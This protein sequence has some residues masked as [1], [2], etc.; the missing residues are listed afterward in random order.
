VRQTGSLL[1]I[2][3]GSTIMSIAYRREIEASL[4]DYPGPVQDQARVSAKQARH[5]ATAIHQ[6]ALAHA[7]DDARSSTPCT[8]ARSGPC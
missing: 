5:A 7:A 8:S 2:A 4:H 3:V 6:P 1:G